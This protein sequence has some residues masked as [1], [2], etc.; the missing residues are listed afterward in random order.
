MR[1]LGAEGCARFRWLKQCRGQWITVGRADTSNAGRLQHGLCGG[2]G[3]P[4]SQIDLRPRAAV[5]RGAATEHTQRP[6]ITYPRVRLPLSLSTVLMAAK[7]AA[8]LTQTGGYL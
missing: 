4:W 3:G 8:A 1:V 2:H 7:R 6:T 5:L